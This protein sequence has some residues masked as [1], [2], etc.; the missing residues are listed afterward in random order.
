LK[1][2]AVRTVAKWLIVTIATAAQGNS[3]APWKFEF[4]PGGIIYLAISLKAQRTIGGNGD[5]R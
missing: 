4:P 3:G 5:F 2:V 1:T